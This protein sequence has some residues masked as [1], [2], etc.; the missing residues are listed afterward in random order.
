LH[1]TF[2]IMFSMVFGT[3]D[4]C[5]EA[6][7][8]LHG[9]HALVRG[10]LSNTVGP[11]PVGTPYCANDATLLQWVHSTL[12]ESAYLVYASA[13]SPLSNEE[14]E[15]FYQES[16]RMAGLFGLPK[17]SLPPT[18]AAFRQY[19]DTMCRSGALSIS[20]FA[21]DLIDRMFG[22]G[23][24][25]L[26]NWYQAVTAQLLQPSLREALGLHYGRTEQNNAEHAWK[27]VRS[28]CPLLPYHLRYVGPY[29]EAQ[30]RIEGKAPSLVTKSINHLWIGRSTL[31]SFL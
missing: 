29:Q 17:N 24:N 28:I 31:R 27:L 26:P 13:F 6:A 2:S 9:R 25:R 22:K 16:R 19:V 21:R 15:Q 14:Q 18:S 10:C 1:H 5:F 8:T 30:A 23:W 7:R 12:V 11:Y 20:P 4:Q 3:I